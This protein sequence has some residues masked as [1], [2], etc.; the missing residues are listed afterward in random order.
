LD[1][2]RPDEAVSRQERL[3][4]LLADREDALR[5]GDDVALA[6]TDDRI[7]RLFD[8]S[9]SAREQQQAAAASFDGGVRGRGGIAPPAGGAT[10]ASANDLLIR[11]LA[12]SRVERAER[13][14]DPG[15]TIVANF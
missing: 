14:A 11:S 4:G 5:A 13:D 1:Q 8:E 6:L 3:N 10:Q 2:P 15:Q 9:R 12:Q 7:D